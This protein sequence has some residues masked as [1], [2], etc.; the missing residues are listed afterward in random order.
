ME[1]DSR[2]PR[3]QSPGLAAGRGGGQKKAGFQ[4]VRGS[5]NTRCC[6][7]LL[8]LVWL[9]PDSLPNPRTSFW[10]EYR[11]RLK[12][13]APNAS[14]RC[15]LFKSSTPESF[16]GSCSC[17]LFPWVALLRFAFG[18]KIWHTIFFSS[19]ANFKI[20]RKLLPSLAELFRLLVI[21]RLAKPRS[22]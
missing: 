6:R 10:Q 1:G 9:K 19:K 8:H 16:R 15:P 14:R 5:G 12:R 2:V 22:G 18:Q 3:R 20:F 21:R 4:S 11:L 13:P 17:G 7:F